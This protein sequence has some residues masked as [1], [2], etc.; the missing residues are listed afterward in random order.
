MT[1][2][3]DYIAELSDGIRHILIRWDPLDVQPGAGSDHP[4][5][6][7]YDDYV[8]GIV[9]DLNAIPSVI[10]LAMRL[11]FIRA[12]SIGIR[13]FPGMVEK[14]KEYA[15]KIYKVWLGIRG[16]YPKTFGSGES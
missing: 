4:P 3:D 13:N 6:D 16:K 8:L 2:Y 7:E 11:T 15:E 5:L 9:E 1:E 14:D 12:I 10:N